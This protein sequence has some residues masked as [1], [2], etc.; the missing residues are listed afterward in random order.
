MPSKHTMTRRRRVER[1]VCRYCGGLPDP[2][3]SMCEKCR[4][5]DRTR[6]ETRKANHE[7]VDCGT[8][9]PEGDDR[10]LCDKHRQSRKIIL[11]RS[12]RKADERE[13]VRDL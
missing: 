12:R 7:C 3:F 6:Y 9:L 1:G 4:K 2:M 10:I 5:K 11:E 8:P 13:D